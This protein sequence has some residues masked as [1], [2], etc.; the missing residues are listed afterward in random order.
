MKNLRALLS[1]SLLLPLAACSAGEEDSAAPSAVT[2]TVVHSADAPAGDDA[3]DDVA[4]GAAPGASGTAPAPA[5][6]TIPPLPEGAC[7]TS[8]LSAEITNEQGAAGSRLV[9]IV[10]TNTSDE[11]CTLTGFPGVSAVTG[12]DGTQVG[13]AALRETGT[14][15][16]TVTLAP[17]AQARAGLKITNVGLLDAAACQPQDADG[18]RIYP[19]E[20]TDSLYVAVPGLQA[21]AGEVDILSV[22]PITQLSP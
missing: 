18:L 7:A 6:S 2:T 22:Q 4:S 5:S 19:P 14:E 15:A 10:L 16:A 8:Q 21:C 20:N 17:G 12:N 9:D 13:P 1:L 11:E 3:A